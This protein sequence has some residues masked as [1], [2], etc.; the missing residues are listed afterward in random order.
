MD[1]FGTG[2][3]SISNLRRTPLHVLKIDRSFVVGLGQVD[4][5]TA[6]VE[7]IIHLGHSFGLDVVAEG[8]ETTGQLEHLVR[9]GCEHGQGFLW[10]KAVH[11]L[12]ATELLARRFD[13]P[14]PRPD[15]AA[16]PPAHGT[17]APTLESIT[18]PD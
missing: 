5:D 17:R 8:V 15:G 9:L 7:S 14:A 1:D 16:A 18:A 2:Y 10:S 12:R 6:I 13:M 11:S 4:T 3:S